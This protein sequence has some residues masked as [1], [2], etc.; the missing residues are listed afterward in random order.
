MDVYAL[1]EWALLLAHYTSDY[2]VPV[3]RVSY[4]MV[5]TV[6]AINA[7]MGSFLIKDLHSRMKN[8]EGIKRSY[9][10][11]T[12][13]KEGSIDHSAGFTGSINPT[14][15]S[16]TSYGTT[17]NNDNS[18]NNNNSSKKDSLDSHSSEGN[19]EST[20]LMSGEEQQ[21]YF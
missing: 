18:N 21:V 8:E 14:S 1:A 15:S 7:S 20:G 10:F 3:E 2:T 16:V 12:A 5:F 6:Q 4:L 11:D 17:S 19:K 9:S 13:T